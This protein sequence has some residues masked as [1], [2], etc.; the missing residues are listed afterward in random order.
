MF[1]LIKKGLFANYMLLTTR[2]FLLASLEFVD[3]VSGMTSTQKMAMST[4][5]ST[6]II[7]KYT[8]SSYGIYSTINKYCSKNTMFHLKSWFIPILLQH[9]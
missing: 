8:N 4:I 9:I 1:Y 5:C 6:F 7:H 3:A 2:K